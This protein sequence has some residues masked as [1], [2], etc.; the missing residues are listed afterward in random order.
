[1]LLANEGPNWPYAYAWM[2]DAM[3]HTL[4][5]SEGHI[6]IMTDGKPSMNTCGQLDQLQV[7]K[8]LQCRGQVVC[9]EGV[10]GGL[11]ALLFDF[12]DLPLRNVTTIN[13]P[14]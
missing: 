8:L 7:W 13:E 2:N 10:N 1:M 11:K 5:S 3:T 6:G 12:E 4:L 9:P 14:T